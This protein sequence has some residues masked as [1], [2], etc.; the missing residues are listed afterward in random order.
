MSGVVIVGAGLAGARCAEALR[1][2][3]WELPV[4]IVGAERV[5]P[6]SGRR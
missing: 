5:G 4:T 6:T 2:G 3:G 1:A